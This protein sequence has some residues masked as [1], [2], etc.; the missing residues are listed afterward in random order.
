MVIAIS[1]PIYG[2]TIKAMMKCLNKLTQQ[3]IAYIE[4][5]PHNYLKAW[6]QFNISGEGPNK[7]DVFKPFL[8]KK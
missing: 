8:L 3:I 6:G 5:T 2:N 4:Y 1:I 7:V